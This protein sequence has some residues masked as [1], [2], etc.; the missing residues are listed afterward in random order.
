ML[1]STKKSL[2]TN[3]TVTSQTSQKT[4]LTSL[5]TPTV[6]TTKPSSLSY[7]ISS[8]NDS[9]INIWNITNGQLVKTIK[10]H[11]AGINSI[12]LSNDNCLASSSKDNTIKTWNLVD[13][14]MMF[15]ISVNNS[16]NVQ[17]INNTHILSQ[18]RDSV[19]SINIKNASHI[20]SLVTVVNSSDSNTNFKILNDSSILTSS[21]YSLRILSTTYLTQSKSIPAIEALVI[22][23]LP[24]NNFLTGHWDKNIRIW[25]RNTGTILAILK[26]HNGP[27]TYIELLRNSLFASA[28]TFIDS[29]TGYS[30]GDSRIFI[31]SLTAGELVRLLS[32]HTNYVNRLQLLQNGNLAS[33]SL[34]NTIK[35][36]NPN[37]GSL[38]YNLKGHTA[39]IL[40][41]LVLSNGLLATGSVDMTIKVWNVV[42]GSIVYVLTGHTSD[43]TGLCQLGLRCDGFSKNYFNF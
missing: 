5:T 24:N 1:S 41:M 12:A 28:S 33:S 14:S 27:V 22:C 11:Q 43:V 36:W 35:I 13:F 2:D 4:S 15:N 17:F 19:Q 8:S 42:N 32:G 40:Q 34:D 38:L 21:W 7:L 26:G 25:S 37:T 3:P 18:N 10:A 31:W 39:P 9:T 6:T 29:S 16:M 23:V 20:K 30:S